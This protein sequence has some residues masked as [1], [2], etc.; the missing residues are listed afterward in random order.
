MRI[1]F[2][3]YLIH[4]E[5]GRLKIHIQRIYLSLARISK[6]WLYQSRY[7]YIYCDPHLKLVSLPRKDFPNVNYFPNSF[8][9]K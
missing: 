3:F 1:L 9:V 7:Q 5:I 2:Y 8:E 6:M 4:F